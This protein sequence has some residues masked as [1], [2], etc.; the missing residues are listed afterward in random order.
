M[1]F[2]IP[3]AIVGL[4]T[5]GGA[6]GLY[7][8]MYNSQSNKQQV[9]VIET[10][11]ILPIKKEPELVSTPPLLPK[12]LQ[13]EISEFN[14]LKLKKVSTTTSKNPIIVELQTFKKTKLR[15]VVPIK[16]ASKSSAFQKE[17]SLHRNALKKSFKTYNIVE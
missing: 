11:K 13:E 15:H 10:P 5:L 1:A 9:V 16:L 6:Y 17:L 4:S 7:N 2:V 3:L 14:K 12:T 8:Y